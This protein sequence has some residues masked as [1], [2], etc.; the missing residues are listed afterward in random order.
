MPIGK[1]GQLSAPLRNVYVR[2][3]QVDYGQ[4][5]EDVLSTLNLDVAREEKNQAEKRN[6][7]RISYT[8]EW[9]TG[10]FPRFKIATRRR[11]R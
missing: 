6:L 11:R 4:G 8:G 7:P 9:W 1:A 5:W 2:V 10:R 3:L